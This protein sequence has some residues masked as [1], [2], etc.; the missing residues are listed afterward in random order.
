VHL[1]NNNWARIHDFTPNK[2]APNYTCHTQ[3]GF[4]FEF[5]PVVLLEK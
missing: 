4:L 2:E 1:Y 5:T 3:V